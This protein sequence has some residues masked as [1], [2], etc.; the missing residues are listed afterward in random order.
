ML[1]DVPNIL[2]Y[3]DVLQMDPLFQQFVIMLSLE[4]LENKYDLELSRG[5][6]AK[7]F[8]EMFLCVSCTFQVSLLCFFRLEGAQEQEVPGFR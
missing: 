5:Q 8:I 3:Y 7:V 4:G 6:R 1:L 2:S